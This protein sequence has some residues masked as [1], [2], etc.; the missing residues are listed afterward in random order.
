MNGPHEDNL[1]LHF[2][3]IALARGVFDRYH[4]F[5]FGMVS[6]AEHASS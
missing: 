1:I 3:G 4:D 2:F 5:T 6:L